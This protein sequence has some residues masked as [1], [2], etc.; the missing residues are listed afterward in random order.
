MPKITSLEGLGH[1]KD[2]LLE[3]RN[4]EAH[5]GITFVTVGMAA[6]GIAAGALDVLKALEDEIKACHRNDIVITRTGCI[7]L[8]RYEPILEVVVGDAPRVA[9]GKVVPA[10]V[11]RIVRE[12]I[13]DGRAVEELVID[14]APF[15][16]I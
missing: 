3:K 1:L 11:K 13:L 5:R 2:E 7:G 16:T 9:Y 4:Q 12:H 15:P 14:A 6:C 10:M 8:C